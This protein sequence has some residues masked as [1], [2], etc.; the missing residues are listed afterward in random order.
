MRRHLMTKLV[1]A[2]A[3]SLTACSAS[4][5]PP[6]D[7]GVC[8]DGSVD[9]GEQCDDGNTISG[10][11][12]SATCQTETPDTQHTTKATWTLKDL[13]TDTA[14]ACPDGFDTASLNSQPVDAG[15]NPTGMP[16]VD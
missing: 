9:P 2:L 6:P 8:G 10:D 4:T 12:C 7:E 15:G 1:H 11:G 13:A 14:T 3:I 5:E 16:V